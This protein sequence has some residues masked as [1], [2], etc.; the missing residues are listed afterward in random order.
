MVVIVYWVELLGAYVHWT[1][2]ND[3]IAKPFVLLEYIHGFSCNAMLCNPVLTK[4]SN[5]WT[6]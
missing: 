5:I 6:Y 2:K 1:Y 4:S 3:T